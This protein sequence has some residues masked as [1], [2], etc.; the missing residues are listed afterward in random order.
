MCVESTPSPPERNLMEKF[1]Y[2]SMSRLTFPAGINETMYLRF[3]PDSRCEASDRR[4]EL[5]MRNF[6]AAD[7]VGVLNA[8]L[9]PVND[10]DR[11]Q[12][13]AALEKC[14]V[15]YQRFISRFGALE[16]MK[17]ECR[18]YRKYIQRTQKELRRLEDLKLS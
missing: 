15:E 5:V 18:D 14:L 4:R 7:C 1:D 13:I 8:K 9:H 6:G 2:R 3:A 11:T 16:H 17:G 10:A 12:M